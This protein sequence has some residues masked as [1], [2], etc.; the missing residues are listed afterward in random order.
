MFYARLDKCKV[1]PYI[2]I[3]QIYEYVY[4][5]GGRFSLSDH[6][7]LDRLSKWWLFH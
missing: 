5:N 4:T 1:E 3:F 2:H 7:D 6:V